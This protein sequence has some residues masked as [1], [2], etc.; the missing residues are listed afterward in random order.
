M[1]MFLADVIATHAHINSLQ[2]K[3]RMVDFCIRSILLVAITLH[4]NHARDIGPCLGE[5]LVG[6]HCF[7]PGA[8]WENDGTCVNVTSTG[9]RCFVPD[10][11][12]FKFTL[13]ISIRQLRLST[14]G[15]SR[16]L[17]QLWIKGN[18]PGLKKN[19]PV[20]LRKSASG[21]GLWVTDIS[22]KYDSEGILCNDENHCSFDQRALEFR[23][24]QDRS[25]QFDMV[26]PNLYVNIP[27]SRSLFGHP[28]YL[29]PMVDVYPWFGGRTVIT[30]EFAIPGLQSPFNDLK[31][32]LLYPPSFDYNVRRRY[33]V[34]IVFGNRVGS[35][36]SPLLESMYVHEASIQEAFVI[37]IN[38]DS[39]APFCGYNP[40]WNRNRD[41]E[42]VNL[43]WR[44]KR[45]FDCYE[46][47]RCWDKMQ[48]FRC[49]KEGFE[50]SARRCLHPHECSGA[51][52]DLLDVIENSVIPQIESKIQNRLLTDF[53]RDRLSI[54][55]F[56]GAGLLACHA[57]VSRPLI[58][59]NA[60]CMSPPF[61]WPINSLDQSDVSADSTG[62]GKVFSNLSYSF[63]FFPEP[64]ALYATQKYYI[65]YGE[66]NN[67]H[68]PIIN[69]DYYVDWFIT[70][71]RN[72]NSVPKEN[73]VLFKNVPMAG[74]N[75]FLNPDGGIEVFNRIRMPLLFFLSVEGS[76]NAVFPLVSQI[77]AA[78]VENETID[79]PDECLAQLQILQEK[80]GL[81]SGIP[82]EVFVITLGK[83]YILS[84]QCHNFYFTVI[85]VGVSVLLTV[86]CMC[87]REG[88]G[89]NRGLEE[90][91]EEKFLKEINSSTDSDSQ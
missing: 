85:G 78:V 25:G 37:T 60:A 43:V 57:A 3:W 21:V 29:S 72:T 27:V 39:V 7:G 71:L 18:G 6:A 52:E 12:D 69:T 86:V 82:I 17:D 23:V 34:V 54:I 63:M 51:G 30:E 50:T 80:E 11:R 64:K 88:L 4:T 58:Y 65:D 79:I 8:H 81:N 33:P 91:E 61:H 55:G 74:N 19:E 35:Q 48:N 70:K 36:I 53:P 32:N 2:L 59:K 46:C 16:P 84:A 90:K 45:E 20:Q 62:I 67:N 44:C 87:I 66:M 31:M 49:N 42:N 83:S 47:L 9:L 22:Y 1:E 40:Y 26:G 75:Y 56:D 15:N 73:I 38:Y 76:P 28:L 10:T 68:F 14:G 89:K 77:T 41:L 5:N 24:Y 13:R